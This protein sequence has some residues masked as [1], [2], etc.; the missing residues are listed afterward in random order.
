MIVEHL[1][2]LTRL[3]VKWIANPWLWRTFLAVPGGH[4]R[5]ECAGHGGQAGHGLR[6][7]RE[8]HVV[9]EGEPLI[10]PLDQ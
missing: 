5:A 3:S 7:P 8:A 6:G 4:Q 2:P 9:G 1:R 10:P